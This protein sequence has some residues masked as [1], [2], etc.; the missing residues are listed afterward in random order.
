MHYHIESKQIE[1]GAWELCAM[2][3]KSGHLD[4]RRPHKRPSFSNIPANGAQ[5]GE[6]QEK[7]SNAAVVLCNKTSHG[8]ISYTVEGV[9]DQ[10]GEKDGKTWIELERPPRITMAELYAYL[11]CCAFF[12]CREKQL[13][14]ITIRVRTVNPESGEVRYHE[15]SANLRELSDFYLSLL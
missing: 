6:K 5:K 4:A 13:E 12:V 9:I 15:K 7:N 10:I 1:L 8:G 3:R 11:R 2:A 14:S